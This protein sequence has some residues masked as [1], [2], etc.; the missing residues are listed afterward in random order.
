MGWFE[1]LYDLSLFNGL[2]FLGFLNFIEATSPH[3]LQNV[4]ISGEAKESVLP[5]G[6]T[7]AYPLFIS[8]LVNVV[9]PQDSQTLWM[10]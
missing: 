6:M 1:S 2:K 10:R 3:L 9:P 4:N 5:I 8:P 7:L